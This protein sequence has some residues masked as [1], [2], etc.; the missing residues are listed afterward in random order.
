MGC[1]VSL[2]LAISHCLTNPGKH[3]EAASALV[4]GKEVTLQ[5]RGTDKYGRTLAD[6]PAGWYQ[7]QSRARQRGLVLVVQEVCSRR[8][9]T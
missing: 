7:R 2:I 3:K 4:F 8:Y 5:T 9:D 1:P 6:V